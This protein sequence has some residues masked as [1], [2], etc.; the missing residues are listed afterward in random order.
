MEQHKVKGAMEQHKVTGAMECDES[1]INV[2]S[3]N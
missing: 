2:L 1:E 3:G